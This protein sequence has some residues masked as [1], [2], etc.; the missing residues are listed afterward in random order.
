MSADPIADSSEDRLVV[1]PL[2]MERDDAVVVSAFAE[3]HQIRTN[4]WPMVAAWLLMS[5]FD[6]RR[7]CL[8]QRLTA[9]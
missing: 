5:G 1:H 9:A 4:Q 2:Y 8:V 6:A 7:W 3:L